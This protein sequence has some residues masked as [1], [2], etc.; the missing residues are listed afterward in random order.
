ML[1]PKE[2][3]QVSSLLKK[4]DNPHEGLPQPIFD[5]MAK[6]TPFIACEIVLA[7]PDGILLTWRE[8]KWWKGWHFPGG[9]MR[10]R[11]SFLDRIQQVAM[12]EIGI[13]IHKYDFLFLKN[14]NMAGR[15]HAVS[16]VFRCYAK[17]RPKKG[18]FFK[19]MPPDIID[20]HK[21]MWKKAYKMIFKK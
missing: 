20:G 3:K 13:K 7:G 11:E 1:N 8:D 18:K 5:A 10:F 9:L 6:L 14:C 17:D 12:R 4:V 19:K 2:L 15:A 21:D 16:L